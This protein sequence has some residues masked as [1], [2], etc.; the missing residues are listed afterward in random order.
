MIVK[1]LRDKQT[2]AARMKDDD[3]L[4]IKSDD[5]KAK[6]WLAI[7]SWFKIHLMLTRR[8]IR[9]DR[10][11]IMHFDPSSIS[12]ELDHGK[13]SA[14][15]IR[16][17]SI[18]NAITKFSCEKYLEKLQQSTLVKMRVGKGNFT[19]LFCAKSHS[20][21]N[22]RWKFPAWER[23]REIYMWIPNKSCYVAYFDL[24]IPSHLDR[25]NVAK[26]FIEL[27]SVA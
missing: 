16:L 24:K 2:K 4:F 5:F 7:K 10:G 17:K 1:H 19:S 21:F 11:W 18:F 27:T 22:G 13:I 26:I 14:F 12:I 8:I 6:T 3:E 23:L 15:E 25:R 20:T 9:C